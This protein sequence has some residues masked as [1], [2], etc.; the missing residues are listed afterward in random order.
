MARW[1]QAAPFPHPAHR[2]GRAGFPHPALGLELMISP[3]GSYAFAH[4]AV[5]ARGFGT[6]IRRRTESIPYSV[7]CAW[8]ITTDEAV[9]FGSVTRPHRLGLPVLR[10]IAIGRHAVAITPVESRALSSLHPILAQV[11]AQG[12]RTAAFPVIQAGRLPRCPSRGLI[13]VHS[14]YGLS[15]RQVA[16]RQPSTP[17]ASMASLPPP[18]L[19]LLPAGATPCRA[20]LAPAENARLF[21]AH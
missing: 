17:E 11:G 18:P 4:S 6:G 21:T 7:F 1:R 13:D 5:P 9:V 14:R 10:A 12:R 16:L 15:A 8:R 2:T 19:R 20:G 3:T